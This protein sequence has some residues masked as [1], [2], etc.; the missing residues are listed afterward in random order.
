MAL[1]EENDQQGV[2][3]MV[4]L[5]NLYISYHNKSNITYAKRIITFF[6]LTVSC[7]FW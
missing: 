3:H 5:G 7:N 2:N 4:Y 6:F 1:G